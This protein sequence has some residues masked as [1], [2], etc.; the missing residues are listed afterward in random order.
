MR[1]TSPSGLQI[2]PCSALQ[3]LAAFSTRVSSTGCRSKKK[4]LFAEGVIPLVGEGLQ[5]CD[6]PIR[7][8]TG[9]QAS[10]QDES[11]GLALSQERRSHNRSVAEAPLSHLGVREL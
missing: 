1:R 6:L 11:D 2:Q 10:D 8:G 4:R 3:S 5:Q 9:L 7:K